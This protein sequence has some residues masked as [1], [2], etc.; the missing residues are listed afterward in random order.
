M[1]LMWLAERPHDLKLT[2]PARL[3]PSVRIPMNRFGYTM[4]RRAAMFRVVRL[5]DG[6]IYECVS[7]RSATW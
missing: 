7:E 6:T 4:E 3:E 2:V 1:R 5:P